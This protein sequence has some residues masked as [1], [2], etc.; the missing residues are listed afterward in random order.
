MNTA[1]RVPEEEE[2]P[3]RELIRWLARRPLLSFKGQGVGGGQ[4]GGKRRLGG[5]VG[6]EDVGCMELRCPTPSQGV[7][8]AAG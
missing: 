3:G 1:A 5:A 8:G 4:G 6:I 2:T 7:G